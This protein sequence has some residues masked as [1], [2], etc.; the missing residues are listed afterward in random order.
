VFYG[1]EFLDLCPVWYRKKVADQ[2]HL[3]ADLS[4]LILAKKLLTQ[5]YDKVIWV[6]ADVVI[7]DDENFDLPLEHEYAFCKE[8]W[9]DLNPSGRLRFRRAV[10]NA[11]CLFTKKSAFLDG[12]IDVCKKIVA[13]GNPL[14]HATIG[15]EFLTTINKKERLD[16]FDNVGLFSPYV[17]LA[18][19][20][21]G[22]F[23]L[24][25]YLKFFGNKMGAANVCTTF[26]NR[27]FLGSKLAN[28]F[29]EQIIIALL[30]SKGTI[31][32]KLLPKIS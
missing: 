8:L 22:S 25:N 29:Y 18:I 10:N 20:K 3:V 13:D 6:D 7:F 17:L 16:F 28:E 12:Y 2:I 32:N 15:T 30:S 27:D 19:Y 24:R 31:L 4:R 5:G 21:N 14:T 23:F 9:V 26:V 11:V 1:D